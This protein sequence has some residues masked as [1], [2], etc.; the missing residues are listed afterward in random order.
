MLAHWSELAVLTLGGWKLTQGKLSKVD[1]PL[2]EVL[3]ELGFAGEHVCNPFR[4]IHPLQGTAFR[5][6]LVSKLSTTRSQ[7]TVE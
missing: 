7:D 5:K 1:T 3:P 6:G 2:E 4:C